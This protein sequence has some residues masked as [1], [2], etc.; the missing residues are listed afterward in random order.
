MSQSALSGIRVLDMADGKVAYGT[1]ILADLGADVIKIEPLDGDPLRRKP[2]FVDD[3]PGP[4]R[5][6]YWLYRNLNKR[7][8]TLNLDSDEGKGL[9]KLIVKSADVV[10][11]TFD[12]GYM[13]GLAL[14][15]EILRQVNPRLIMASITDFGQT[16]PYSK[17][18]G[19]DIVDFAMSGAMI[20][21]GTPDRP[22][23]NMPGSPA[24]DC[25]A[26]YAMC[27]VMLALYS[28]AST[29]T[30]QYVEI[31]VQ[32][33]ALAGLFSWSIPGYSY[34][35]AAG[36][37]PF[38]GPR[39]MPR[40]GSLSIV[41]CKDGYVHWLATSPRQFDALYELLGNP[42]ELVEMGNKILEVAP[43]IGEH[44]EKVT[45]HTMNMT[46]QE[47]FERGQGKHGLPCCPV[48][49]QAEYMDNP[50][51][52]ARGF[53]REVE[54]PDA[55]RGLYASMPFEMTETPPGV[56]RPA[57]RLGQHNEEI[58]HGDL[59]L[60]PAKIKALKEAGII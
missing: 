40:T 26:I 29:G 9:F 39:M 35:S 8:V 49:T 14:D 50:H 48:C 47:F 25:G 27:G 42:P 33:A 51:V 54:H 18:K 3:V 53:F 44:I 52:R 4:D 19:S 12:P 46:M 13:K 6:M 5:S 10:V 11:E 31:S 16:G 56:F 24:R 57:P 43:R 23:V 30:G 22:P 41:P 36:R 45:S 37:I 1:R 2:P 32:E 38:A 34:R 58:F 59:G 60:S 17:Y 7:S 15:Y 20:V 21:N 55:G 28:R